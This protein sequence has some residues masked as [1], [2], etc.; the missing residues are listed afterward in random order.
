M[1]FNLA[2][3]GV[4]VREVDLTIGRI[5]PANNQVAGYAAPFQKGPINEPVLIN[6][7]QDLL[8]VFGKPLETDSQ[9]EYWHCASSYLSY[10]GVLRVVRVDDAAL[11]NANIGVAV[12]SVSLKIDSLDDF[13]NNHINDTTGCMQQKQLELGQII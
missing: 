13:N 1:A 12:S 3:P 2:S 10:G 8:R 9:N 7:E 11:A 6:G 5:D 4:K